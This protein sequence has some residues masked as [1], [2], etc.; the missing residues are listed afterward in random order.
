MLDHDIKK[1]IKI[2]EESN[3]DELEVSTLWGRQ[4]IRL[5]KNTTIVPQ[6]IDVPNNTLNKIH[7]DENITKPQ[8][9][10]NEP[11]TLPQDNHT[12]AVAEKETHVPIENTI[13]IKSPLVGTFYT[14]P[15]PETAPFIS[16]GDDIKDGQVICII[17]AMKIFNEIESEYSG[18]ILKILV[19]D[20]TPVEYDQ[21]LLLIS[22]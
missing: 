10:T 8:S 19:E 2:L 5:R 18:K 3:I 21:D 17:E 9:H 6:N 4:K 12:E 14:S 11:N 7:L 15:N 16:V 1:L 22:I 20:G 13:N